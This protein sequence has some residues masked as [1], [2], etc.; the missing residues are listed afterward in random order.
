MSL[1]SIL[2]TITDK[3]S[4]NQL[5]EI[6]DFADENILRI[7]DDLLYLEYSG[8]VAKEDRKAMLMAE[9][10]VCKSLKDIKKDKDKK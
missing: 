7:V 1:K 3:L 4:E 10:A 5:S 2:F 6:V 8:E 9:L